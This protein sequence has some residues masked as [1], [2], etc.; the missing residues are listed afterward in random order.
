MKTLGILGGL[1]PES[2]G[3]FY[4]EI[5]AKFQRSFAP[6]SNAD[7]PHII[8]NS[9][10]AHDLIDVNDV[11]VL[12]AYQ[13]G[14]RQL[15][16]WGAEEIVIACNSAYCFIDELQRCSKVPI[17]DAR[18]AVERALQR[19]GGQQTLVLASPTSIR[20]GLYS[21]VSANE[22]VLDEEE[23]AMIGVAIRDYNLGNRDTDEQRTIVALA[24]DG[25]SDGC[26]IIGG[27]TEIHAILDEAKI[28]HI[29]PLQEMAEE[30][31]EEWRATSLEKR[32]STVDGMG[33]FSKVAIPSDVILYKI[34]TEFSSATPVAKWAHFEGRWYS[35]ENVLN[36]VNHA[37][38]PNVEIV[39]LDEGLAL[40]SIRDIAADEEIVCDYNKTEIGGQLTP[41]HCGSP[42][43]R[44]TFNRIETKL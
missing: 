25:I 6:K 34:P 38:D 15:E 2:T 11:T 7:Y 28:A 9:I 20:N 24:R 18:K 41:C 13:D 39:S 33:I 32:T 3:H 22:Q 23:I 21:F 30:V 10:P 27:C 44:G 8:V 35:D 29:D 31:F 4:L 12:S 37:C 5:I 16:A 40:R 14:L 43:C 1:G 26:V 17:V 36:W 42:Q 19:R